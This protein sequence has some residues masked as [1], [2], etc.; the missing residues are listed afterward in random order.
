MMEVVVGTDQLL[1]LVDDLSR[2]ATSAHSSNGSNVGALS[3]ESCPTTSQIF[4][5]ANE[6]SSGPADLICTL[7]TTLAKE[8]ENGN[9]PSIASDIEGLFLLPFRRFSTSSLKRSHHSKQTQPN[10]AVFF[11]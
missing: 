7:D 5:N 6:T 9:P 1:E 10:F 4:A 2:C 3:D 8:Y 11:K